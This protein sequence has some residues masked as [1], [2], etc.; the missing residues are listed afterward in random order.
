M[1]RQLARLAVS[2]GV[3]SAL[4]QPISAQQR[5]SQASSTAPQ[6][7][8]VCKLVP[9]EE[10]RKH[11]PWIDALDQM[12]VDE[13]AIGTTGSSCNY[14]TVHVQVLPFTQGFMDAARR[15]GPLETI[16]GV[17]DE[18]YFRN[19]RNQYAEIFVRI[20]PRLLTLQADADKGMETVKPRVIELAKVYV[21]KLR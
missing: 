17:G 8:E 4:S 1:S 5:G 3:I 9:K 16:S 7:V 14:P 19:N 15:S 2:I 10:V 21:T 13:E 11:L 12:P 18:A 6:R 20:G